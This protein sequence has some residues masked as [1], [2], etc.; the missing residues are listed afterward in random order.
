MNDRTLSVMC[1]MLLVSTAGLF[2]DT[3]PG[4]DVSGTWYQSHSPY[5][6]AGNIAVP[7]GDTLT[8]EPGVQ[9]QFL[10]TYGLT[11]NGCLEAVGTEADS[12]YFTAAVDW[13][14]FTFNNASDSSHLVYCV[15]S[16]A[17]TALRCLG[18]DPVVSHSSILGSGGEYGILSQYYGNPRISDCIISGFRT[19]IVYSLETDSATIS[20]CT[21]R[22]N[23]R[24]GVA[25]NGQSPLA[26]IDCVIDSNRAVGYRGAGVMCQDANV[27][28]TNCVISN[29]IADG[30]PGGGVFSAFGVAT[31]TNCTISGNLASYAGGGYEV[32]GGGVY[33]L[34]NAGAVLS[35]CTIIDNWGEG[36][37]TG[38]AGA[39]IALINGV[40]LSIDH[41]TFDGN[42]TFGR[43]APA[44]CIRGSGTVAITNSI[45]SNH[46][47]SAIYNEC[48]PTIEYSDFANNHS[49]T[50]YG[51]VPAGFGV[52]DTVNHNGDS[53]DC[54]G[55]IFMDPMYV[56]TAAN[57]FHLTAGSPCI[58]AGDPE[59]AYDPDSTIT[60]MGAFWYCQVG[61]REDPVV[62]SSR[63]AGQSVS[64]IVH[65][66]LLMPE[67]VGGERLAAGAHL[68]DISGR[69]VLDLHAGSN[70][71]R[72]LAPGVYFVRSEPSAASR[73]PMAVRKVIVT[74]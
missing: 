71:V 58:D 34:E 56:D 62:R 40:S 63:M 9:I 69:K 38:W 57:D 19:G 4:G 48:T 1:A 51:S 30:Q 50:I 23:S 29:N 52:L 65:G 8:I 39:G 32:G 60:D 12:I 3:I 66:V 61:T 11:V 5:Y 17:A 36:G 35:Y 27:H 59:F 64:T 31:F 49:P 55:N 67:A 47:D 44:M 70:D 72:Q 21:I 26:F 41:C 74:R 37:R 33:L 42:R 18:G 68:L 6:V 14:G 53:C 73:Q 13:S 16:R 2:A 54:Y 45:V 46:R 25:H 28:F 20:G 24:R 43:P 22:A 10:G 7:G 15:I